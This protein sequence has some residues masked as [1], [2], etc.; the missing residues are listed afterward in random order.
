MRAQGQLL[1]G[2]ADALDK[3][4]KGWLAKNAPPSMSAEDVRTFY[5]SVAGTLIQVA[6]NLAQT[7]PGVTM[8]KRQFMKFAGERFREGVTHGA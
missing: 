5:V 1:G 3:A 2:L 4:I 7:L 6:A 8:S